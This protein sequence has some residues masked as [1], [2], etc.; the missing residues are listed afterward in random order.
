VGPNGYLNGRGG[1]EIGGLAIFAPQ[2]ASMTSMYN[3]KNADMLPYGAEE[4]MQPALIEQCLSIGRRDM[5]HHRELVRQGKF[6]LKLKQ[7]HHFDKKEV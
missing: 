2:V 7:L 3:Y 5:D 1:L 6:Y 4:P